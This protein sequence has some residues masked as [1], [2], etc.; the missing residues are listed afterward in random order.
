MRIKELLEW[1]KEQLSNSSSPVLDAE[2][3]LCHALK[4]PVTFLLAHDEHEVPL[5]F[6]K[7]Y[8]GL[9]HQRAQGIPVVYLTG[10]KEFYFLE[11]EVNKD[12]LIPRPDTEICEYPRPAR[13]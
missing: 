8:T 4:K 3:L 13:R 5:S 9:I 7:R 1:G 11:F 12:V 6:L 10:S 2:V